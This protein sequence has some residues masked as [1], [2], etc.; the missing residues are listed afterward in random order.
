[1]QAITNTSPVATRA[2]E[3][4]LALKQQF[5]FVKFSVTSDSYSM[6]TSISV[7]WMDGGTISQVRTI[8][9]PFE[10]ID[11]DSSSGEIQSGGN[12]F[13]HLKRYYSEE[14]YSAA[15]AEV[16]KS[17]GDKYRDKFENLLFLDSGKYGYQLAQSYES[18]DIASP[19]LNQLVKS[20][21][22]QIDFCTS[23]PNTTLTAM[24]TTITR[25]EDKDG[26]E[27]R[28]D[29]KPDRSV[30]N[31]LV[32]EGFKYSVRQ[33][34]WYAVFSN[35]KMAFAE[36]LIGEPTPQV[37]VEQPAIA[38]P[39]LALLPAWKPA[40]VTPQVFDHNSHPDATT[41]DYERAVDRG[42]RISLY[43]LA[44]AINNERSAPSRAV[45]APPVIDVVPVKPSAVTPP[46]PTAVTSTT[47]FLKSIVNGGSIPKVEP[48]VEEILE[49][50]IEEEFE[51]IEPDT[52]VVTVAA[53]DAPP[54]TINPQKP[55][56]WEVVQTVPSF[57]HLY[58]RSF[59]T[60]Q[61][62]NINQIA[63]PRQITQLCPI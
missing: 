20:H 4:R 16:W 42:E 53:N 47:D 43:G 35:K 22:G 19:S 56:A 31:S 45:V 27:V 58:P 51:L 17:S 36:S 3:L 62:P 60:I 24:N 2:K 49:P 6:G 9:D 39:Q 28:F 59:T 26:I 25:N 48:K 37:P 21:L 11:R 12:D 44:Q 38:K 14:T 10:R 23:N 15:L 46:V 41:A 61:P 32:A 13:I 34:L 18:I 50:E 29:I 30:L 40:P 63:Y 55:Q 57:V 5:P 1:M 54:Q 8:T 52:D 7:C 33:N